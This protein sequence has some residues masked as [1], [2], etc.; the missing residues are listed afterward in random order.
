M[1]AWGHWL[2]ENKDPGVLPLIRASVFAGVGLDVG[3][4][5]GLGEWAVA[6]LEVGDRLEEV[7]KNAITPVE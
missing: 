2:I 4:G 3:R 6:D 1:R 7:D 5:I